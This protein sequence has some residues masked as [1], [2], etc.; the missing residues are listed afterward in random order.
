LIETLLFVASLRL[1]KG[2]IQAKFVVY[3]R[4]SALSA[5]SR[6][7]GIAWLALTRLAEHEFAEL[8]ALDL[9]VDLVGELADVLTEHGLLCELLRVVLLDPLQLERVGELGL[10]NDRFH[11]FLQLLH[12]VFVLQLGNVAHFS[13]HVS[14]EERA[15]FC[16]VAIFEA[17]VPA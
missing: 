5:I 9:P 10:V 14:V 17:L 16:R 1:F 15:L 3:G 2:R 7:A 11:I 13:L 8:L 4:V 6:S 12:N